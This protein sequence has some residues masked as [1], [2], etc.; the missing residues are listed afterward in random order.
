MPFELEFRHHGFVKKKNQPPTGKSD[1]SPH[2]RLTRTVRTCVEQVDDEGNPSDRIF[3]EFSSIIS[4]GGGP[5]TDNARTGV[6]FSFRC[7][8]L[9]GN[10]HGKMIADV[11]PAS[12]RKMAV[13]YVSQKLSETLMYYCSNVGI[14]CM[15]P[16]GAL[17]TNLWHAR[18]TQSARHR[19]ETALTAKQQGG[20]PRTCQ[21]WRLSENAQ[22][23]A[24][25]SFIDIAG[26]RKGEAGG[27]D[28]HSKR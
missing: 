24:S 23:Q 21:S 15:T 19:G 16:C 10:A 13:K 28:T 6:S 5:H 4:G 27:R 3:G 12:T 2:R 20:T 11:T 1:V 18:F 25:C 22:L 17:A 8:F 9:S 7:S 26:K 14:R